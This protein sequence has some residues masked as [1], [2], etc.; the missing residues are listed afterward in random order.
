MLLCNELKQ[1]HVGIKTKY[2]DSLCSIYFDHV[3][4]LQSKVHVS[5]VMIN[6]VEVKQH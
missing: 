4:D 5:E 2:H 6:T 1:D 3:N